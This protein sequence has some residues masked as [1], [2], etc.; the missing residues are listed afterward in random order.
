[1]WGNGAILRYSKLQYSYSYI[2][3]RRMDINGK[4]YEVYYDEK[5]GFIYGSLRHTRELRLR[6]IG[7]GVE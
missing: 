3:F 2:T 5:N 1:M 6:R 4:S 7:N